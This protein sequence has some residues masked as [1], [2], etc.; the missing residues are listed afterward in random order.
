MSTD[1]E[2]AALDQVCRSLFSLFDSFP[3]FKDQVYDTLLPNDSTAAAGE[4]SAGYTQN[5]A[6][7]SSAG[8]AR[9]ALVLRGA[10]KML[11]TVA[12]ITQKSKAATTAERFR[13]LVS[14]C[15]WVA[16]AALSAELEGAAGQEGLK[17]LVALY[18]PAKQYV[19][20][21]VVELPSG[22]L[23]CQYSTGTGVAGVDDRGPWEYVLDHGAART[24]EMPKFGY[25]GSLKPYRVSPDR[26][27][28]EHI[29]KPDYYLTGQAVKERQSETRNT[30]PVHTEKQIKKMRKANKLGREILDAAHRIIKPGVTTDEIDRVVHEYTIEHNAYPAP[31]HYFD[32]PKSV[33]TSVN[34]V[35]CH[36]IP[37]LREL[38]DGDIV[39]VD[40]SAIL[41]GY[42]TDLNETFVVGK[43]VSAEKKALIKATHD[44]LFKAIDMCKPGTFYRDLGGVI[45]KHIN[46]CGFQVD[47]TYC[48]HGI[49]EYFHCAPNI[50]H[51]AGNKAKFVM[52]AGHIFT[53][54]PMVN[55]GTWRDTHWIDGWT[56]VTK[57]GQPSAQFEHTLLVNDTGVEILTARLPTS[58]PLWWEAEAAEAAGASSAGAAP[59]EVQ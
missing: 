52:K 53:I 14:K 37:D 57:D 40:V 15:K 44:S 8:A 36:G 19:I 38:K 58:P 35:V 34:E 22:E 54:E 3:R 30:P 2:L 17:E 20:V 43:N 56:A 42:H 21:V 12:M 24:D 45:T 11:Q 4:D 13:P 23:R 6:E 26:P 59:M 10:S 32:F 55:M 1:K 9:G 28:P 18:D 51:Y 29:V 31:L 5:Y 48:G 16:S 27:V 33:C 46:S 7:S 25:N 49:G 50:P 39:N 41:D 47:R